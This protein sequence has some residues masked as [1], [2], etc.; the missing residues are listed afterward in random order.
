ML[1][2]VFARLTRDC[3]CIVVVHDCTCPSA[4][5]MDTLD[6]ATAS[7]AAHQ[8]SQALFLGCSAAKLKLQLLLTQ[9]RTPSRPAPAQLQAVAQQA[10]D[11][12]LLQSTDYHALAVAA[13]ALESAQHEPLSSQCRVSMPRCLC[14]T[15]VA[16][17]CITHA[18]HL[19]VHFLVLHPLHAAL[20]SQ[21]RPAGMHSHSVPYVPRTG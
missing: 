11:R 20:F 10:L 8:S 17:I 12:V 16:L 5:V 6:T 2:G 4:Q 15:A 1:H 3:P 18:C 19:G 14:K 7:Q 21:R 9:W 13:E